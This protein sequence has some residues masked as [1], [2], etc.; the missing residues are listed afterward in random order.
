MC[1]IQIY[2][3][4]KCVT[5]LLIVCELRYVPFSKKFIEG[6]CTRE[7]VSHIFNSRNI[8]IFERLIEGISVF[9]HMTHIF[10]PR[11]IPTIYPLIK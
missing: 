5:A 1:D 4:M 7:H 9:E 6:K 3:L 2:S 8:P 10:N 11:C